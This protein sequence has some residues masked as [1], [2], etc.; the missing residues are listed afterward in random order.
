M[1]EIIILPDL[2]SSFTLFGVDWPTAD[3]ARTLCL[4][5]LWRA[6]QLV[7]ALVI[8]TYGQPR[9]FTLAELAL[10]KSVAA[11]AAPVLANAQ[12]FDAARRHLEHVQ[13]L[14]LVD[15]ALNRAAGLSVR[16][17]AV[18][19]QAIHYLHVEAANVLLFNPSTAA[20][21][22]EAARGPHLGLRLGA[23]VSLWQGLASRVAL[24]DQAIL[25]S[26]LL[27]DPTDDAQW[28]VSKGYRAYGGV[29]LIANGQL[30]GVLEVVQRAPLAADAHWLNFFETLAG[31]AAAAIESA[32]RMDDL[33]R[34]N[35]DLAQALDGIV[36]SWARAADLRDR[37]VEGHSQRVTEMAL[38]LARALGVSESELVHLRRGALL[39]D[40]GKLG[41]PDSVLLKP[42][43]LNTEEWAIMRKHP[44]YA[45]QWLEPIEFLRPALDIPYCH[46]ER[47]DGTGYPRGLKGEAIPF[48]A[49]I[50]AVADI[51]D[52]LQS[53]R[54]YRRGW[55]IDKVREY[56]Y[57]LSGFHLDP[58]VVLTF[59]D[60]TTEDE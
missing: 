58:R 43:P 14:R 56:I 40:I 32:E 8:L 5:G 27:E 20:F 12:A 10:L 7:G 54:P 29:P 46:H 26:N 41:I 15:A 57:S 23:T 13:A 21:Q 9:Q 4:V 59:L 52:A 31:Q 35:H 22:C 24:G 53:D 6:G 19:D 3:N 45:H 36:A 30:M 39:H 11:Q 49:R 17:S 48:S 51:W 18:L 33:K 42:G 50:F 37:E 2:R 1:G 28:L 38:K 60:L 25:I 47:W 44:E 16:L 55:P 34:S